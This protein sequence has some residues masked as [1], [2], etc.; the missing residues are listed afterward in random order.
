ML[1]YKPVVVFWVEYFR[2]LKAKKNLG[3]LRKLLR[4]GYFKSKR[5]ETDE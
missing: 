5:R 1:G 2:Q 3:Y 4:D